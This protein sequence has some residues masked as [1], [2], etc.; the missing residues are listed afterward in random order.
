MLASEVKGKSDVIMISQIKLGG[1]FPV[2][3]FILEG[4]SEPF[5]IDRNKNG[6]LLFVREDLR[7]RLSSIEKA[8]IE[9]FFIELNLRKKNW[10]VNCSYSTLETTYP[11][12][13]KS[14]DE[15]NA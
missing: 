13:R 10:I 9:S 14:S 6:I 8:P 11:H 15:S 1:T 5:R 4:F 2:D 7:S 3:R 12:I